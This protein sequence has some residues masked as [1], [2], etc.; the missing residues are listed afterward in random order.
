MHRAF[1]KDGHGGGILAFGVL[2][3]AKNIEVA[4]AHRLQRGP[5]AANSLQ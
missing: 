4:Q 5:Q 1:N 2:A 3:R